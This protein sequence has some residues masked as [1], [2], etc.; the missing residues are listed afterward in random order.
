MVSAWL[1]ISS[2]VRCSAVPSRVS[3]TTWRAR[4]T[5]S[6]RFRSRSRAAATRPPEAATRP[7]GLG[8]H[9]VILPST[10]I[11][12]AVGGESLLR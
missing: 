11:R 6:F 10:A 2:A 12:S 7:L 8:S 1:T 3:S 4:V 9:A 5:R